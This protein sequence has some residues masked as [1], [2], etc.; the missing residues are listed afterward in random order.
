MASEESAYLPFL[1]PADRVSAFLHSTLVQ[2][3]LARDVARL[4]ADTLCTQFP[5]A[6]YLVFRIDEEHDREHEL[7]PDSIRDANG[8]VLND[9]E[10]AVLPPLS[11]RDPLRRGW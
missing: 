6:A 7:F 2:F 5:G 11:R 9:F 4:I 8:A 3:S 1:D 10:S